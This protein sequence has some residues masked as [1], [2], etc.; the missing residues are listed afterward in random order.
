[1]TAGVEERARQSLGSSEPAIY[2]AIARAIGEAGAGGVL[3]DIGCGRGNLW[4]Y[5]GGRFDRYLAADAALY[6]GL[7]ECAEFRAID[8]D[9]GRIPIGPGE[10]DVVVAAE[11]IE[12]LENPRA[13]ARELVRIARPGGWVLISTPNQLSLLSLLTL[14]VKSRFSAF[15]DGMY[16][17]HLTALLECDLVRIGRE[18]GLEDIRIR[19]SLSGRAPGTGMHYPGWLSRMFP[20]RLS[21]NVLMAG[22]KPR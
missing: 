4:A 22:R 19:Y 3:A 1:V 5:A 8:L 2:E 21:D 13:L 20:R 6:D 12:H 18:C 16:P 7:P 9:T 11:V 14:A 15:Q 17:A 10:A